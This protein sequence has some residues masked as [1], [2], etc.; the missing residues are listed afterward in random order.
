[1]EEDAPRAA[2]AKST[3]G[4]L[5]RHRET[6]EGKYD[7]NSKHLAL[8]WDV[9]VDT[10]PPYNALLPRIYAP[11]E[12]FWQIVGPDASQ[13]LVIRDGQAAP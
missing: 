9:E 6:V 10:R 13:V 1:M 5:R 2:R 4:E 11:E 12:I 7:A 3:D 8:Y